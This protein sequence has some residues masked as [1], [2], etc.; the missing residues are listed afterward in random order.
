MVTDFNAEG[1]AFNQG[2]AIVMQEG[3][4]DTCIWRVFAACSASDDGDAIQAPSSRSII[5]VIAVGRSHLLGFPSP[6][7]SPPLLRFDL[8]RPFHPPSQGMFSSPPD[9]ETNGP[10]YS[11]S[12]RCK[13]GWP[14]GVMAESV[15]A[16]LEFLRQNGFTRAEAAL[17]RELGGRLDLNGSVS[18]LVSDG[19]ASGSNGAL[20][21]GKDDKES[22]RGGIGQ[23]QSGEVSRELIVKEVECGSAGNGLKA[24][25][26][27]SSVG[28][29]D[30]AGEFSGSSGKNYSE[31]SYSWNPNPEGGDVV[32][33]MKDG[34][35]AA[36]FSSERQ[37]DSKSF[38]ATVAS[39]STSI[40]PTEMGESYG[41]ELG[42]QRGSWV[43][44]TSKANAEMKHKKNWARDNYSKEQILDNLWSIGETLS[45]SPAD[46]WQECSVKT[47]LPFPMADATSSYDGIFSSSENRKD[48]KQNPIH[49]SI[50]SLDLLPVRDN[51]KEELPRL[52]PVKLKS[53]D[54]TMDIHWEKENYQG[55]GVNA[56]SAENDFMIGS[57]F[58]VPIGQEINFSEIMVVPHV[59]HVSVNE[60]V[61]PLG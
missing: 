22:T 6:A 55:S 60:Y 42:E 23:S 29:R 9:L 15:D 7:S 27:P 53:E 1:R 13:I 40:A 49:R 56:S 57:F 35:V 24:K 50:E 26:K 54:K 30:I 20:G 43:G 14:S 12:S 59:L 18:K 5:I 61:S 17:C 21:V 52:P 45:H 58:D 46:T 47:V 11:L 28:E 34:S 19:K 41:R 51:H 32:S 2:G 36:G 39:A 37:G 44:S 33:M 16:I 31:D 38:S 4:K 48:G 10:D 25:G 3:L 8:R